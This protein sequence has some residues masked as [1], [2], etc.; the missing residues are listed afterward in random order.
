ML[1][2]RFFKCLSC[3][4]LFAPVFLTFLVDAPAFPLLEEDP[5]GFLHYVASVDAVDKFRVFDTYRELLVGHTRS[6]LDFL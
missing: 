1:P 6:Q 4:V 5:A 3:Y 2:F